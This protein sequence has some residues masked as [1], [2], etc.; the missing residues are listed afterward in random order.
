MIS[1]ATACVR[2]DPNGT[3]EVVWGER[4]DPARLRILSVP[5]PESKHRFR[6]IV[7]NDGASNG[8]REWNGSVVPVFDELQL[9]QESQ[10]STFRVSLNVP[11][12]AAQDRLIEICKERSLGIEDWGTITIICAEC[13][14]GNPG[15]HDCKAT[16]ENSRRSFA[17]A[18]Q[19][20]SEVRSILDLWVS[21]I[22]DASYEGIEIALAA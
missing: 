17:F 19:F 12:E 9:W 5:L 16:D 15:P 14:R 22:S 11:D 21:E 1:P 8:E 4:V 20:E 10:Y 7:L 6:D 18:A 3:G 2:L 13:S